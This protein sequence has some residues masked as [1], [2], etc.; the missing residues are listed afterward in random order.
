MKK[1]LLILLTVSLIAGVAVACGGSDVE[2]EIGARGIAPASYDLNDGES[3]DGGFMEGNDEFV[4]RFDDSDTDDEFKIEIE[5]GSD[6]TF[7]IDSITLPGQGEDCNIGITIPFF[8]TKSG[9]VVSVEV[10][11]TISYVTIED[12]E[13]VITLLMVGEDTLF[14]FSG[15]IEAG[16]TVTGWVAASSPAPAIYPPQYMAA[17]IAVGVPEGLNVRVNLFNAWEN[18]NGYFISQDGSFAF[19]I[20][21]NTEVVLEDGVEFI[22]DEFDG[23]RI[24]VIYGVSTRSIPE[25][26]TASKLIVLY[27]NIM[28][29]RF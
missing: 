12:T 23:R 24:I 6:I 13:G 20:D 28:P 21:E 1:V 10:R 2:N 17:V 22:G 25:M 19:R 27:E 11:D 8:I 7:D 18:N 3:T 15:H 16:E 4:Y 14:P 26:T 9:T 29:V 5:W